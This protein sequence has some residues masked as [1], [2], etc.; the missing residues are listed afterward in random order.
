[1]A[2]NCYLSNFE[3]EFLELVRSE[4]EEYDSKE[5]TSGLNNVLVFPPFSNRLRFLV[6]QTVAECY[7]DFKTFSIG[8]LEERRL[9]V[10]RNRI[11]N[12]NLRSSNQALSSSASC[13]EPKKK[14]SNDKPLRTR[15]RRPD[16]QL[17]IPRAKRKSDTEVLEAS[18]L[19][20]PVDV[21]DGEKKIKVK[22]QKKSLLKEKKILKPLDVKTND[23]I[24]EINTIEDEP[25]DNITQQIVSTESVKIEEKLE[26]VSEQIE[27]VCDS[28]QCATEL[29]EKEIQIRIESDESY[30]EEISLDTFEAEPNDVELGQMITREF[31]NAEHSND[32]SLLS[33]SELSPAI[34]NATTSVKDGDESSW[35]ALY[36]EDGECL[37]PELVQEITDTLG[38]VTIEKTKLDY[39]TF[40][41][42]LIKDHEFD[43]IIEIYDFPADF[44]T[45]D[46]ISA[47][48]A[49]R[50]RGF[51]VKWVDDTHALGL[52]ASPIAAAEA[53]AMRHSMIK[54]RSLSEGTRESQLKARRSGNE[55]QPYKPRP[56]TSATLARRLVTGALGLNSLIPREQRAKERQQ[57]KDAKAKKKLTAKQKKDVWEGTVN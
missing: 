3:Y 28:S 53:L 51:D 37:A 22:S 21:L 36:N 14:M 13:F 57:L 42:K 52:F 16:M 15:A 46:L 24:I 11:H 38:E 35:E 25:L 17:Y 26:S 32:L 44:K 54:T 9:V 18:I 7:P 6:H 29:P 8:M 40:Q 49:F 56:E 30:K 55:L 48:S 12:I 27:E 39:T 50:L 23:E 2:E 10:Y 1:M 19:T 47:F 43:H 41:D 45:P 5:P 20:P 4:I 31:S 33:E 34:S